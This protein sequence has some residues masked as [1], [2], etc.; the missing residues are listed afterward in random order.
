MDKNEKKPI[1]S[2][3]DLE[4][5]QNSYNASM[6]V[7]KE[8]I[9]TLP[10][11]EREDL[12]SQMRRSSKAV[13]RLIAEGFSKRHQEKGFQKYLD[14]AKGESNEMIVCLSQSR[15]LYPDN[16]DVTR[17]DELIDVYD[18]TARQL[19]RLSSVWRNFKK[20][21]SEKQ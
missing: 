11:C 6:V 1:K 4:V 5:Y 17:C 19:H 14:D 8:I 20:I 7:I 12:R 10:D 21:E 18:K 13:P 15:D 16:V 3:N 9:N 2:Y